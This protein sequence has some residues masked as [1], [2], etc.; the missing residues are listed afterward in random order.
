MDQI[1][2]HQFCS[3]NEINYRASKYKIKPAEVANC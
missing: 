3:V 2:K 1:A